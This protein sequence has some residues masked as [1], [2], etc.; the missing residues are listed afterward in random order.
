MN[1]AKSAMVLILRANILEA[2]THVARVI[3]VVGV[4]AKD[5]TQWYRISD[6]TRM[7][8]MDRGAMGRYFNH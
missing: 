2:N 5:T 3:R 7:R 1:S 8:V 6:R 4:I